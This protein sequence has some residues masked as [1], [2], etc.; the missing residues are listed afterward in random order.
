MVIK[1]EDGN[2]VY[3]GD[4]KFDQSAEKGYRTDYARLTEIGRE[5]VL[6]LLSES[7][8]AENPRETV[9][10]R[11]I[12]DFISENFEYRKGRIIVACVA[13]IFYE[14]NKFLMQLQLII[15]KWLLLDMM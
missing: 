13:Q 8:N 6:A 11:A 1:T 15:E 14:Y 5:G 12:Y 9:N 2:V 10:E 3:T 4:F 7:A